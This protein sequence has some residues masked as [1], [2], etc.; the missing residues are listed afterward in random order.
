MGTGLFSHRTKSASGISI[1]SARRKQ[2]RQKLEA[3]AD[4]IAEGEKPETASI[5]LGFSA[6]YGR[7]LLGKL[8]KKLGWQAQ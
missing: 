3:F 7:V 6:S 4:L 8:R 2:T 1:L 5:S